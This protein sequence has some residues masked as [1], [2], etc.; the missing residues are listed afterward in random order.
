[1]M[2]LFARSVNTSGD[3]LSGTRV[4]NI[5]FSERITMRASPRRTDL[6]TRELNFLKGLLSEAD[7]KLTVR[8]TL[9]CNSFYLIAH[10]YAQLIIEFYQKLN[11]G[12]K[13]I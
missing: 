2:M 12:F 7:V 13:L 4:C 6:A 1:L 5:T 11:R 9:D 10:S 8:R 3:F